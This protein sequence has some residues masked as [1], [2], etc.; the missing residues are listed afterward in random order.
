MR[1]AAHVSSSLPH[2]SLVKRVIATRSSPAIPTRR[3]HTE[4]GIPVLKS[5]GPLA[6]VGFL[7]EQSR[8]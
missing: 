5:V 7:T 4:P 1:D 2:S 3:T 6:I 8:W